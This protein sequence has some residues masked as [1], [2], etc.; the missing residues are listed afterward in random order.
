MKAKHP[1]VISNF[2]QEWQWMGSYGGWS[3][4]MGV[5]LFPENF[6]QPAMRP[7]PDASTD[8]RQTTAFVKQLVEPLRGMTYVTR[9]AAR[10]QAS[11][12]GNYLDKLKTEIPAA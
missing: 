6:L 2:D 5:F 10:D 4:A 9:A 1:I 3:S 11:G 7:L 12:Q 8:P